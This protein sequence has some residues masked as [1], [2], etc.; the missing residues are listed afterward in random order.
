MNSDR[1]R[2][3]IENGKKCTEEAGRRNHCPRTNSVAAF[4]QIPAV[5]DDDGDDG[6]G[7][8]DDDPAE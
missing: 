1:V 7:D 3:T 6:G 5:F 4:D 2:F 8:D